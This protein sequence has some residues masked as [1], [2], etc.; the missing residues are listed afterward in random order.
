MWVRC[1]AERC[2]N[3]ENLFLVPAVHQP[4]SDLPENPVLHKNKIPSM[5][6]RAEKKDMIVE[7][8]KT[9][10]NGQRSSRSRVWRTRS[11]MSRTRIR[12]PVS[13]WHR[14]HSELKPG[15][16]SYMPPPIC[17]QWSSHA[18]YRPKKFRRDGLALVCIETK[19]AAAIK[20]SR[21]SR[22]V[23]IRQGMATF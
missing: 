7:K 16:A 17:V 10:M 21:R 13:S 8:A 12:Q 11:V 15:R 1:S 19:L 5:R 23:S 3:G 2:R 6:P 22:D 18:R 20:H 4:V 14:I 9:T